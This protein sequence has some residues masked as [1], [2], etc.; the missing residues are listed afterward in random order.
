MARA[1]TLDRGPRLAA[2]TL[3]AASLLWAFF[4]WRGV[5]DR[6]RQQLDRLAGTVAGTLEVLLDPRTET[7]RDPAALARLLRERLDLRPPLLAVKITRGPEVL[8][9][10]GTPPPGFEPDQTRPPRPGDPFVVL[11]H[12]VGERPSHGENDRRRAREAPWRWRTAPETRPATAEMIFDAALTRRVY[13]NQLPG[14]LGV[15]LLAWLG[16]AAL[17]VAWQRSIRSQ[18]LSRDL[19]AERRERARLEELNLAAAGLAHETKNPLGIIL[20]L[21]QRVARAS[22]PGGETRVAAEQIIDAADRAAA[23]LSDF[24]TFARLGRPNCV[25]TRG[26]TLLNRIASALHNDFEDAGVALV[27][28]AEPL[29][30]ACAPAM[31]EQIVVNLLLNSLAASARGATVTLSLATDGA[32]AALTVEDRGHGIPAELQAEVFKP[33][34]TGR[35]DGHGLGLA[36]VKRIVDEHGWRIALSSV[37]EGGTRVKITG[38][39]RSPS[40]AATGA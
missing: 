16:I 36:I 14:L 19:D 21:A 6:E 35:A 17:V 1:P 23:R 10:V 39:D 15:L 31:V 27:V 34:V 26:D 38:I 9:L 2:A 3:F 37:P 25:P 24:L 28:Q 7:G 20:G 29:T 5:V 12:R 22:E 11:R 30:V 33:Y 18:A 13:E 4:A 40:A 8:A 32:Q